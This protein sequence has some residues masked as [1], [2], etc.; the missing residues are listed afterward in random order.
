VRLVCCLANRR[1]H[2][3][4]MR[5]EE[6]ATIDAFGTTSGFRLL[7]NA[8]SFPNVRFLAGELGDG[9]PEK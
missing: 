2:A 4:E 6:T 9:V 7:C 1:V 5:P 8:E 3:I